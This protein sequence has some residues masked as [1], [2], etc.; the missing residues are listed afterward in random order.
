MSQ[1]ILAKS[2]YL[3]TKADNYKLTY[4]DN[5]ELKDFILGV[6]DLAIFWHFFKFKI[7]KRIPN[8]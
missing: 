8:L 5:K 6:C 1:T 2:T 4:A 7:P 3:W